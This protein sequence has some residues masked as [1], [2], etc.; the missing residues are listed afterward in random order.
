[1]AKAKAAEKYALDNCMK[2]VLTDIKP[3]SDI[4]LYN[5]R[6]SGTVI[7]TKRYDKMF[8]ERFE[9]ANI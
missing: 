4:E 2:F 7:F 6:K 8:L 9:H 1:M 3:L 5:L